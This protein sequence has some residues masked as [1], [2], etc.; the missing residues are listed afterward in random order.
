MI[1]AKDSIRRVS[2][3]QVWHHKASPTSYRGDRNRSRSHERKK[4]SRP[5]SK[6]LSQKRRDT[7]ST[8]RRERKR[9]AERASTM[10]QASKIHGQVRV[11]LSLKG[12]FLA[13]PLLPQLFQCQATCIRLSSSRKHRIRGDGMMER[14][15]RPKRIR[16]HIGY[17]ALDIFKD[18]SD[19][20]NGLP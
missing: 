14:L 6:R 1:D 20:L 18:Q 3:W 7:H 11:L 8:G 12:L 5:T 17:R 13:R 19:R 4:L 15:L 9:I 10:N 2:Q 16:R